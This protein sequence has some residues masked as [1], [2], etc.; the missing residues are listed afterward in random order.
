MLPIGILAFIAVPSI[1]LIYALDELSNGA[2]MVIQ[3]VGR[4]WYW[5]YEYPSFAANLLEV[6]PLETETELRD[7]LNRD[8][9]R[10][11]LRLLDSSPLLLPLALELEF[12]TAS[13]D[14]IHGFALPSAGIKMDAVPGRLNQVFSTLLR[15][16]ILYGQ[17]SELCGS[18]HGFMPITAQVVLAPLFQLA[19]LEK[20]ELL[21]HY[22]EGWLMTASL[23]EDGLDRSQPPFVWPEWLIQYLVNA[24]E[25]GTQG[26]PL[27]RPYPAALSEGLQEAGVRVF[28]R[29]CADGLQQQLEYW[30]L[31]PLQEGVLDGARW[32]HLLKSTTVLRDLS[33]EQLQ[34][35]VERLVMADEQLD[36]R[37][38]PPY[39]WTEWFMQGVVDLTET[40]EEPVRARRYRGPMPEGLGK[41][42]YLYLRS[43]AEGFRLE[44]WQLQSIA[45]VKEGVSWPYLL[46]IIQME[47]EETAEAVALALETLL[48]ELEELEKPAAG[49]ETK[50]N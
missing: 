15:P 18:G 49:D 10:L 27:A 3:V 31:L 42:A 8:Y 25:P 36:D 5:V 29:D 33:P 7:P 16:G 45:Q 39:V 35:A 23:A 30:R 9:P 1:S 11:G 22:L 43:C 41:D 38:K 19:M 13:E 2:A 26:Q 50:T 40:G 37:L 20:A 24:V 4:Q 48:E 12:L 14:V 47:G 34:E 21:R 6:E 17:C 44:Y 32:P 46:G 28:L